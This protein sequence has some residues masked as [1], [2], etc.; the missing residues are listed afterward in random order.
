MRPIDRR[1]IAA[2]SWPTHFRRG[3]GLPVRSSR[4]RNPNPPRFTTRN[5]HGRWRM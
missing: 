1:L 2:R 5:A 4:F 3:F